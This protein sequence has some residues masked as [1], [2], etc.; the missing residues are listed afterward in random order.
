MLTDSND[1]KNSKLCWIPGCLD[2]IPARVFG[3]DC[4]PEGENLQ[5]FSSSCLTSSLEVLVLLGADI[6]PQFEAPTHLQ[7][8]KNKV[9]QNV[10]DL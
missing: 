4:V 6:C 2:V 8:H 5:R 9:F 7:N 3:L 10:S 1:L